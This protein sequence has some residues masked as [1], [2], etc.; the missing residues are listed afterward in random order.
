MQNVEKVEAHDNDTVTK[1]GDHLVKE[2]DDAEEEDMMSV[3]A[4]DKL[5]EYMR[6]PL[7]AGKQHNIQM[8]EKERVKW[9][10]KRKIYTIDAFMMFIIGVFLSYGP[11]YIQANIPWVNTVSEIMSLLCLAVSVWTFYDAY[12]HLFTRENIMLVVFIPGSIVLYLSAEPGKSYMNVPL[13]AL[14]QEANVVITYRIM[15]FLSLAAG[16]GISIF[17]VTELV[18]WFERQKGKLL[19]IIVSKKS[20][21]LV[22]AVLSLGTAVGTFLTVFIQVVSALF[23]F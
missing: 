19:S 10:M 9:E 2:V 22:L 3:V 23:H 13:S 11:Q 15:S 12:P 1:E 14:S 7:L 16:L 17:R 21:A 20:F 5:L 18:F 8:T 6:K 4:T